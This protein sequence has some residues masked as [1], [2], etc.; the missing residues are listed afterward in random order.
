MNTGVHVARIDSMAGPSSG[1]HH[2]E[3]TSHTTTVQA[4]GQSSIPLPDIHAIAQA[5]L[6]RDGDNLILTAHDGSKII[7]E[8]YFN[9]EPTPAL[10][11]PQGT[12]TPELVKSFVHDAHDVRVA[13]IETANDASPVGTIK[14]VSGHATITHPD[15]TVETAV[16]G[17]PVHEGDIIQT[18]AKGAVNLVFIDESSFAVSENAKLAIDKYVFDP[19]SHSG[20]SNF[21]MLRGLFVYTSGLIGREDPDDVKIHTPVGSIGIRGTVIAGNVDKGEITVVE[22]AIVL[23]SLDGKDMTL[24]NQYETARFTTHGID[25]TG[26]LTAADLGSRFSSIGGVAAAFYSGLTGGSDNAPAHNAEPA[27]PGE[28]H[29]QDSRGTDT[30]SQTDAPAAPAMIADTGFTPNVF[31]DTPVFG[32]DNVFAAPAAPTNPVQAAVAP[33]QGLAAIVPPSVIQPSTPAQTVEAAQPVTTQPAPS[34]PVQQLVPPAVL[35]ATSTTA[36]TTAGGSSGAGALTAQGFTINGQPNSQFG[37][38]VSSIGDAN[39]DG[40][41]DVLIGNAVNNQIVNLANQAS[42]NAALG[43]TVTAI[44]T[45]AVGDFNGDGTRDIIVGSYTANDANGTVNTGHAVIMDYTGNVITR[46]DGLTS[47]EM[48]GL[49]VSG[50]GDVNRDGYADVLVG[51]PGADNG[52]TDRGRAYLLFGHSQ[53]TLSQIVDVGNLN[54]GHIVGSTSP[55]N[56]SDLLIKGNISYVLSATGASLEIFDITDPTAPIARG[57]ITTNDIITATSGTVLDGLDNADSMVIKGNY[58]L[59]TGANSGRMTVIDI[60]NPQLPTYVTSVMLGITDVKNLAING[61]KLIATSAT[62]DSIVLVDVTNPAA[63]TV[64]QTYTGTLTDPTGIAISAD[65]NVAYIG[66]SANN[67]V[68]LVN[69]SNVNS[70]ATITTI[71]Q[72]GMTGIADVLVSGNLLF[73]TAA[74]SG[75]LFVYDISTPGSP[76]FVSSFTDTSLVGASGLEVANNMAYISSATG[77]SVTTIDIHDLSNMVRVNVFTDVANINGAADL[78]VDDKGLV[79]VAAQGSGVYAV[80]ETLPDGLVINGLTANSMTGATVTRLGDFNGDGYDDFAIASPAGGNGRIDIVFGKTGMT[81]ITL[82]ADSL[83]LTNIA[84]DSTGYGA[85]TA[86]NM[87]TLSLN[88][89]NGYMIDTGTKSII[90]A[91]AVGDYNGDGYDDAVVVVKDAGSY[92]VDLYVMYGHNAGAMDGK[93][94][95]ADLGNAANA[96]H[97]T[98]TIPSTIANPDA[99]DFVIGGAGDLNGDGFADFVVGLPNDNANTG[100]AVTVYGQNTTNA[101]TDGSTGDGDNTANN[102]AATTAQQSVVGNASANTLS[103]GGLAGIAFS[104]GG[105]N[106]TISIGNVNFRSIDGGAGTDIMKFIQNTGTLD[107]SNLHS[108]TVSRIENIQM[109]GNTQTVVLT[110]DNIFAMLNSSD[111]GDLRISESGGGTHTLVIDNQNAGNQNG[112]SAAAIG[113]M[114]GNVHVTDQGAYYAFDMGGGHTLSIDRSLVDN[115][116][117]NVA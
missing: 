90:G 4:E 99:F 54:S 7:V 59:I 69:I 19:D 109:A 40:N 68:E 63:P 2:Q 18:D 23:H 70:P 78:A 8:N 95:M 51:A 112:A 72:A 86:I 28:P 73:I 74:T 62:N 87:S 83:A 30:H 79:H 20:D 31:T 98:Y 64:G 60:S 21:S 48:A 58:A 116:H 57:T 113:A 104:A 6:S 75:R 96:F 38:T 35:N 65:G 102:I 1:S 94:D 82:G 36:G 14:E 49:S 17:M 89:A 56:P 88:G 43:G 66:S 105:G 27:K 37:F 25:F 106:D 61:N 16:T 22:G 41:D 12:L 100:A 46:I 15:G 47:G 67:R 114:L 42:F 44:S 39:H 107:F 108:E 32:N 84:T 53:A 9:A 26:T 85:N 5:D 76:T 110:L 80:L 92:N 111:T 50:A 34:I 117:V 24:S 55:N 45:S 33:T 29:G 101:V 97:M 3:G 71:T 91:G 52:G 11:T 77:N 10:T 13:G 103:D 93:M 81:A 115:A